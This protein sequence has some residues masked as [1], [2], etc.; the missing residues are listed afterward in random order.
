ME[1]VLTF[2]IVVGDYLTFIEK[3]GHVAYSKTRMYGVPT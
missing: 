3:S 1:D 2:L